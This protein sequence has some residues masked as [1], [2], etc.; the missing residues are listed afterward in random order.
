MKISQKEYTLLLFSNQSLMINFD[1]I[2]FPVSDSISWISMTKHRENSEELSQSCAEKNH[3]GHTNSWHIRRAILIS[4]FLSEKTEESLWIWPWSCHTI[5]I[6]V[7]FWWKKLRLFNS[8]VKWKMNHAFSVISRFQIILTDFRCLFI[9]KAIWDLQMQ[10]WMLSPVC[11][12][13]YYYW[14]N[15]SCLV[16][17]YL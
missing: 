6:L 2:T 12:E 13:N 4:L 15:N 14:G 11:W 17:T 16:N 1:L 10:K 8:W 3:H 5:N 9:Q 7:Y